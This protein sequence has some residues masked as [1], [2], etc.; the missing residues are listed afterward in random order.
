MTLATSN[1]YVKY[2]PVVAT[3]VFDVTFPLFSLGDVKVFVDGAQT[4]AFTMSGTFSEGRST[5]AKVTLLAPASGV[6]V[7]IYGSRPPARSAVLQGNSPNLAGL[8][9]IDADAIT[10]TQQEQARDF[11]RSIRVPVSE[12]GG[13][14]LPPAAQRAGK[15]LAFDAL[16]NFI[17]SLLGPTGAPVSPFMEAFLQL[18]TAAAARGSLAA[19]GVGVN[20]TFTG[21]NIFA[22]TARMADAISLQF[23]TDAD[24]SVYYDQL[25]DLMVELA[26][27]NATRRV[28]RYQGIDFQN[29]AA[30]E[31]LARFI[32]DGAVEL[33]HN[34]SK[35]AETD[36][37]GVTVTGVL[38]E[39][40]RD[41]EEWQTAPG[42]SF[43][44]FYQNTT[45]R[46][47]DVA[48]RGKWASGA[49]IYQMF[50]SVAK[51]AVRND[52]CSGHVGNINAQITVSQRVPP[53]HYYAVFADAGMAIE[54]WAEIF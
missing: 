29:R 49:G 26:L 35:K 41:N 10:A 12:A 19:A 44:V 3:T 50:L 1:R 36:A 15:F 48:V 18:T 45:G 40:A 23:G 2:S 20:N 30:N 51:T 37:A 31:Y 5:D 8:I 53:G 42:R 33:Y 24:V 27:A 43:G 34:G 7:E 47:I 25:A 17:L 11:G 46:A 52:I 39:T 54:R 28:M 32:A 14:E 16:G 22:F 4:T 9:G 6:D 21:T 13:A 38:R